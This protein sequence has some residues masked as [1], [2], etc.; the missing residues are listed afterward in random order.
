MPVKFRAGVFLVAVLTTL[1]S[2]F[3]G[4]DGY[5]TLSADN[6]GGLTSTANVV[7]TFDVVTCTNCTYQLIG[8][9]SPA[10]RRER[11]ATTNAISAASL[12]N[13]T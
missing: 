3:G 7:Y 1:P 8:D 11:C 10:G 4:F 2:A 6:S 12:P 9:Q 5:V 13:V